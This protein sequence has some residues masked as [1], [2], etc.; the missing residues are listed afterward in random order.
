MDTQKYYLRQMSIATFIFIITYI[1]FGTT[2]LYNFLNTSILNNE[3]VIFLMLLVL[4]IIISIH[5]IRIKLVLWRIFLQTFLSVESKTYLFFAHGYMVRI[6]AILLALGCSIKIL[7]FLCLINVHLYQYIGLY[8]AF[9]IFLIFRIR[10]TYGGSASFLRS[11]VS[12]LLK[13]YLIPF[14]IAATLGICLSLWEIYKTD[15]LIKVN[16]L[17]DALEITIKA[18]DPYNNLYLKPLR[19]FIRH[20][21][22]YE[23]IV[24]QIVQFK[25]LGQAFYFIYLVIS[26]GAVTFFGIMLLGM[27]LREVKNEKN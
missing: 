4:T 23:L 18:I 16:N 22:A 24:Q 15:D 27:P 19:I 1:V 12:S 10:N 17:G 26:E 7:I 8:I 20:V 21:Y 13:A 11:D 3:I 14:L 5:L 9:M 25:P 6:I 2:Y